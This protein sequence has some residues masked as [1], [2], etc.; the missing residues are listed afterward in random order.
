MGMMAALKSLVFAQPTHQNQDHSWYPIVKGN[1]RITDPSRSFLDTRENWWVFDWDDAIPKKLPGSNGVQ[2]E[3]FTDRHFVMYSQNRVEGT[4]PLVFGSQVIPSE[5]MPPAKL[6]GKLHLLSPDQIKE[7]DEAYLKDVKSIR[8]RV[9]VIFPQYIAPKQVSPFQGKY[10]TPKFKK[11]G[12][13]NCTAPD[14]P[15]IIPAWMY[16]HRSTPA[17]VDHFE[18]DYGLFRH[19][20]DAEF[21]PVDKERHER[22][23]IKYYFEPKFQTARVPKVGFRKMDLNRLSRETKHEESLHE[24][25]LK[26]DKKRNEVHVIAST[27]PQV[28]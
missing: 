1:T 19:R 4:P 18:M 16:F 7:L 5:P 12:R 3:V 21:R 22:D 20:K 15:V 2:H 24:E 26:E 27:L 14:D 6:K 23:E 9:R 8:T 13:P 17:I 10:W 25:R 28:S 11:T